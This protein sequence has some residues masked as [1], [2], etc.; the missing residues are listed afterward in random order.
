MSGIEQ[1]SNAFVSDLKE[2]QQQQQDT[3]QVQSI[4]APNVTSTTETDGFDW[5]GGPS[6]RRSGQEGGNMNSTFQDP[7]SEAIWGTLKQLLPSQVRIVFFL[8]IGALL[9]IPSILGVLGTPLPHYFGISLHVYTITGLTILYLPGFMISVVRAIAGMLRRSL[10]WSKT[11][12]PSYIDAISIPL[13]VAVCGSIL[14][15]LWALELPVCDPNDPDCY[16]KY[17][18]RLYYVMLGS[19]AAF[20][21]EVAL[22]KKWCNNYRRQTYQA[23][24]ID[25]RFKCYIVEQMKLAAKARRQAQSMA[26]GGIDQS[27]TSASQVAGVGGMLSRIAGYA[28]IPQ[29]VSRIARIRDFSWFQKQV[30]SVVLMEH[31]QKF[32]ESQTINPMDAKRMAKD[33]FEALCPEDRDF[34]VKDDFARFV[35][36]DALD[37]SYY[38][39]DHDRDG[40]VTRLEFRNTIV[41]IFA[42][43]RHLAKAIADAD[44]AISKMNTVVVVAMWICV[45]FVAM[46]LCGV[47]VGNMLTLSLSTILG[48]NVII[49]DVVR[50]ILASIMFVI[51]NHTYDIGDI[52]VIGSPEDAETLV[53]QHVNLL[54]TIFKRWNGQEVY[55]ANHFL[56][57]KPITNLSRSPDQWERVDFTLP[58]N[59]NED[60][61]DVMRDRFGEF[62]K[63]NNADFFNAFDMRAVVAA[64]TGKAESDLEHI[65]FSLRV[66]CRPTNDAEKQWNRH[67]RL[68]KVVK[69]IIEQV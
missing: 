27:Q 23:R 57:E 41:D 38:V 5:F 42:E 24:I 20:S 8:T 13:C 50:S 26:A 25:N 63:L 62:F 11:E 56:I 47:S 65:R 17:V 31:Y 59:V 45:S 29:E 37:D 48:V 36:P 68:L 10:L 64:D 35:P 6:D 69:R 46:A 28:P 14:Y 18:H 33:I 9:L 40:E 49:G 51:V 53:V 1:P 7:E 39:F 30:N 52:I 4:A 55:F 12:L 2:E 43:Q 32:N 15:G 61:L 60:Q 21:F 67:S 3:D 66:K 34:L 16:W 19:C 22:M 58:S 54:T 44:M